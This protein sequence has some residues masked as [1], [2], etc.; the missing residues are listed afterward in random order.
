MEDIYEQ[1]ERC[2]KALKTLRRALFMRLV[3]MGILFWAVTRNPDQTIVWGLAAFI[4]VINFAGALP[5][6][7]E[8]K[9]QR[10]Q[11]KDL[12]AQEET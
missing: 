7:A 10:R 5:L 3:V 4:L 6:V 8:W 11:L 2:L 1:E 12:I 9:K